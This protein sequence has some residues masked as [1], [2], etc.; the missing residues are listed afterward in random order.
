MVASSMVKN[1]REDDSVWSIGLLQAERGEACGTE[2]QVRP[3][4]FPGV[5]AGYDLAPGTTLV[6]KVGGF[7]HWPTGQ[8]KTYPMIRVPLCELKTSTLH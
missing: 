8:S 2:T 4:G 3:M 7:G 5:L 1:Q 6:K